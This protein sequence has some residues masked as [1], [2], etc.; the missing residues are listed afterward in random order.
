MHNE[1]GLMLKEKC[2]I[3]QVEFPLTI[4]RNDLLSACLTPTALL[5]KRCNVG[6]ATH[7]ADHT[8]RRDNAN[9]ILS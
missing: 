4:K 8:A 6:Y 9:N 1:A 3:K 5:S 2:R 7:V